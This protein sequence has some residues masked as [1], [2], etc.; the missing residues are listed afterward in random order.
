MWLFSCGIAPCC[1]V[2]RYG[3]KSS[4]LLCCFCMCTGISADGRKATI[5]DALHMQN[6]P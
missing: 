3:I 2:D 5:T 1:D 6:D 4:P